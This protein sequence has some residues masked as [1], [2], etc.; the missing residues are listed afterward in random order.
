MENFDF[1]FSGSPT[2]Y[3][4]IGEVTKSFLCTGSRGAARNF[5]EGGSKSSEMLATM[6][7]QIIKFW[8]CR[9]AKT[10]NSG[11]FSIRFHVL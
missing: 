1:F 9:M 7:G 3:L 5:L 2:H 4:C 6:V 11:P 10:V 8:V